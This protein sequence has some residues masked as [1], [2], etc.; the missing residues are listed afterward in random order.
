MISA[1]GAYRERREVA[2]LIAEIAP[3]PPGGRRRCASTY[4][5]AYDFVTADKLAIAAGPIDRR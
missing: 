1:A 4:A 3:D 2:R 5:G